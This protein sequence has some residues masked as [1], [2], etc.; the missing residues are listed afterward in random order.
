MIL[1]SICKIRF[2][3]VLYA[4]DIV[5]IYKN[6]AEINYKLGIYKKESLESSVL[7]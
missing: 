2:S 5:L 6:R 4:N 3:A 1:L 7:N